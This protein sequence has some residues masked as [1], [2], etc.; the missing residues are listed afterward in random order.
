[1]HLN[2]E[3]GKKIS[4]PRYLK[5]KIY[6]DEERE[7]ISAATLIR[8]TNDMGTTPIDHREWIATKERIKGAYKKQSLPDTKNIV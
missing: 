4:M 6:T 8:I 1:M 5:N 3:D 2:I 7:Q